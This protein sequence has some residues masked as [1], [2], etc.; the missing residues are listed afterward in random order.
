MSGALGPYLTGPNESPDPIDMAES[1]NAVEFDLGLVGFLCV[2]VCAAC[3]FA[4]L[5]GRA[6]DREFAHDA[7]VTAE[8]VARMGGR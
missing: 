7:K 1:I 8:T 4:G 3:L 5:V 2:V 6:L